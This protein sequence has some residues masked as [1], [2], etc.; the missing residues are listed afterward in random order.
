MVTR[1]GSR[2]LAGRN[3]TAGRRGV[4]RAE[5]VP[6][7][8]ADKWDLLVDTAAKNLFITRKKL[9][10]AIGSRPYRGLPV[11]EE[12][13]GAR[14]SQ[15]RQDVPALVEVLKSNAKYTVNGQVLVPKAL[16][17]SIQEQEL[18][19]RKGGVD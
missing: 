14:W 8:L 4:A 16:I 3:T 13:L 9:K 10:E 15:I 5:E 2:G 1:A 17:E 7:D 12:E 6:K 11:T 18:K 19:R